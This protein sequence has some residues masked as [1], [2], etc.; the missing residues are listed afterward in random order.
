MSPFFESGLRLFDDTGG[1]AE[2]A[3]AFMTVTGMMDAYVAFTRCAASVACSSVSATT[4]AM[5]WPLYRTMLSWSSARTRVCG[6]SFG[7]FSCVRILM[8]PGTVRASVVSMRVMVPLATLLC[9][10]TAYVIWAA[11]ISA[12]YF[13]APVTFRRPSTRSI[14]APTTPALPVTMSICSCAWFG[15]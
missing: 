7:A 10:M 6:G 2:A 13:A 5:G 11:G 8:T 3:A 14:G 4:S 1:Y 9:T 15:M 12:E